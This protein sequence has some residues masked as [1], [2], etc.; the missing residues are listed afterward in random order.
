MLVSLLNPL[1]VLVYY[2]VC[3]CSVTHG[4]LVV[5]LVVLVFVLCT[6]HHAGL[7]LSF[8]TLAIM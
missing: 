6:V 4:L 7:C 3:G 1:S 2:R 8:G 5:L